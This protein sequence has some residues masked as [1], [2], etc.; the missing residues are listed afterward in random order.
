M[1][2]EGG[3]DVLRRGTE[4]VGHWAEDDAE[5]IEDSEAQLNSLFVR[6]NYVKT[7]TT[8]TEVMATLQQQEAPEACS[9]GSAQFFAASRCHR[10]L[11]RAIAPCRAR[12]PP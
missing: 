7:M 10:E 4:L 9:P 1:Q 2:V 5:L 8:L 6:E 12:R 11:F 3:A